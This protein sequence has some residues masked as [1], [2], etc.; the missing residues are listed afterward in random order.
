LADAQVACGNGAHN[1]VDHHIGRKMN[2]NA[3]DDDAAEPG[4]GANDP[5]AVVL[6]LRHWRRW[7]KSA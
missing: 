6:R 1:G 5:G 7:G 2:M 4:D 3:V